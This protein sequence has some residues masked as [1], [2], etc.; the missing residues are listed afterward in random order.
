MFNLFSDFFIRVCSVIFLL[1]TLSEVFSELSQT[2][3]MK[4]LVKIVNELKPLYIFPKCFIVDVQL[5]SEMLVFI[6]YLIKN[7]FK[8]LFFKVLLLPA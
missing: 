8:K 2:S 4:L 5:G 1:I 3:K 7:L 6:E